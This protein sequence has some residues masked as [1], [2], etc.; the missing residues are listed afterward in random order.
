MTVNPFYFGKCK[1]ECNKMQKVKFQEY[2]KSDQSFQNVFTVDLTEYFKEESDRR[3]LNKENH[4]VYG[5]TGE[6]GSG[7]SISILSLILYYNP[8]FKVENIFWENQD[9]LDNLNKC[10]SGDW[11]M[12]DET[13]KQFG[14]GSNRVQASINMIIE[15]LR[16]AGIN[17]VFLGA[18]DREI[19]TAH[20][21]LEVVQRDS[22]RRVNRIAVRDNKNFKYLGYIKLKVLDEDNPIWIE[23]N[24]KKDEYVRLIQDQEILYSDPFSIK[25]KLLESAINWSDLKKNE[26]EVYLKQ[27]FPNRT[28]GEY[29]EM[30]TVV[31]LLIKRGEL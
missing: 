22:V 15:T 7:K 13:L 4:A 25:D 18:I 24:K 16:K 26:I 8:D 5:L 2:I 3:I 30:A 11:V 14:I 19:P 20:W 17:F 28:I 21:Y 12:R 27:I 23:Y 31:N 9:I 10:S 6:T 29:K 1:F